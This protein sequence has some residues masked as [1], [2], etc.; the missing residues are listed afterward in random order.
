[1]VAFYH[2]GAAGE[3]RLR[4]KARSIHSAGW[5]QRAMSCKLNSLKDVQ[6]L[7]K[8]E[9]SATHLLEIDVHGTEK[10]D[11]LKTKPRSC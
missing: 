5:K 9:E 6:A 2:G 8:A 11:F 7:P 4:R 1:M 3:A 10:H